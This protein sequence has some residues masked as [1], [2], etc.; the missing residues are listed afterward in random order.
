MEPTFET[1]SLQKCYDDRPGTRII[2]GRK[3]VLLPGSHRALRGMDL[4]TEIHFCCGQTWRPTFREQMVAMV[5]N[6]RNEERKYPQELGF[7]GYRMAHDLLP[8]GVEVGISEMLEE[9]R[10]IKSHL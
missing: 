7:R 8:I 1:P 2:D 5:M 3:F 10:A 4:I 9:M 6:Y